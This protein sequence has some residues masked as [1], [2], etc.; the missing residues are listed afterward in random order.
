MPE[1]FNP[2]NVH[3]IVELLHP[4]VLGFDQRDFNSETIAAAHEA[5]VGI[6]VDRQTPQEWQDAIDRGATGIQTNYPV[7]L[8]AFLRAK[9]LHK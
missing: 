4:T 5:N 2:D 8:M 7:E 3:K 1:A 6:F 9:G